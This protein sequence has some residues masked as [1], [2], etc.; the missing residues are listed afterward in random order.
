M[1]ADLDLETIAEDLTTRSPVLAGCSADG[2][3]FGDGS[4][5]VVERAACEITLGVLDSQTAYADSSP[6]KVYLHS[7]TL[8]VS[9]VLEKQKDSKDKEFWSVV[10]SMPST[11]EQMVRRYKAPTSVFGLTLNGDRSQ[12]SVETQRG[13]LNKLRE[14]GRPQFSAETDIIVQLGRIKH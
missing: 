12:Q 4:K 13:I 8:N 2:P 7:P 3:S 1:G 14:P 9:T 10:T 6:T 5:R 11:R